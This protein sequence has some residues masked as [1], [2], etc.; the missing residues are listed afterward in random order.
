MVAL[1]RATPALV[2]RPPSRSSA[3]GRGRMLA[4]GGPHGR[5]SRGAPG[6]RLGTQRPPRRGWR[7]GGSAGTAPPRP[8]AAVARSH[9]G[10]VSYG[11]TARPPERV[12]HI[13]HGWR[14]PAERLPSPHPVTKRR[15]GGRRSPGP[16]RCAGS[17]DVDATPSGVTPRPRRGRWGRQGVPRPDAPQ[18]GA[19]RDACA[20]A[21][22]P[23]TARVAA[24]G[25]GGPSA[26]ALRH[27]HAPCNKCFCVTRKGP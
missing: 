17:T 7:G 8:S 2:R 24:E 19:D 15:G 5:F 22:R 6:E 23:P 14:G 11:A 25:R 20:G 4:R 26:T 21:D 1:A 10:F 12:S 18:G 3:T 13:P 9:R 27:R 16:T